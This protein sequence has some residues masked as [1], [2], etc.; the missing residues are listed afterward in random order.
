M[1][2]PAPLRCLRWSS[3]AWGDRSRVT[4]LGRHRGALGVHCLGQRGET[5]RG[6]VAHHDLGGGALSVG[7]DSQIGHRRHADA[8]R[9]HGAV[10]VDQP[11]GNR[12]VDRHA[13][14]RGGL[15]EAVAET[16]RAE[17]G[18]SE[19]VDVRGQHG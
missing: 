8:T 14:E 7:R 18:G 2:G 13:L 11:V 5:G 9:R 6:L 12:V 16:D 1:S 4:D 10:E 3:S 17:W 15:D 19:R